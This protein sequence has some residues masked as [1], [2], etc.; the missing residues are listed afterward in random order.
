VVLDQEEVLQRPRQRRRRQGRGGER[1]QGERLL[2]DLRHVGQV[3]HATATEQR[4]G[5]ASMVVWLQHRLA[6]AA[7]DQ[8]E[9]PGDESDGH[10]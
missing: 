7:V 2:T 3:L 9:T 5:V 8:T 6:E 4:F 1:Q 10:S